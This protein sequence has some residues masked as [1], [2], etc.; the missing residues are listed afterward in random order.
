MSSG[1]FAATCPDK[2]PTI[3][4]VNFL[5][6]FKIILRKRNSSSKEKDQTESYEEHGTL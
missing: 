5:G 3:L 4:Q 2:P 1:N 6:F